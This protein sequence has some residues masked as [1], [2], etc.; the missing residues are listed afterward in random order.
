[1]RRCF[2]HNEPTFVLSKR[3]LL[4]RKVEMSRSEISWVVFGRAVYA[5]LWAV[6]SLAALGFVAGTVNAKGRF[7]RISRQ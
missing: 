7:T 2:F 4:G 6:L 1:M 3:A 5:V